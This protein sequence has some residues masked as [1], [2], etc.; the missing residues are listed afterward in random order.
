M[1]EEKVKEGISKVTKLNKKSIILKIPKSE[2]GDYAWPCFILAKKLKKNPIQFAQELS[3]KIKISGI[4]T[5]AIQGYLNFF[6][7][8]EK[9]SRGIIT[10]ILKEK[11]N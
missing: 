2:F 3:K 11:K 9:F 10:K 1:F 5:K 8:K 6:V 7:D 4:K